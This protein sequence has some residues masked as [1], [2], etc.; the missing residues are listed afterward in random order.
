VIQGEVGDGSLCGLFDLQGR[1]LLEQRLTDDG[2]NIVELPVGL[3]GV[4][5]VRV[6]DGPVVITRKLVIP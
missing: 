1:N 6:T 2:M 5:L 3:H 4:V